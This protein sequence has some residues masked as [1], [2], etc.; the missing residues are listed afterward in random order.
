[1]ETLIV[2][3]E[4]E[5]AN[6]WFLKHYEELRQKYASQY[7]AIDKSGKVIASNKSMKKLVVELEQKGANPATAFVDYVLPKGTIL[8]L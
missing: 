1:M 5:L 2:L 6:R 7:V 4:A 8:L 3:N